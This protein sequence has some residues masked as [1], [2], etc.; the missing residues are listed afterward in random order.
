MSGPNGWKKIA[1]NPA[2][3]Q[4]RRVLTGLAP[5]A[6]WWEIEGVRPKRLDYTL[7]CRTCSFVRKSG[8]NRSKCERRFVGALDQS[9]QSGGP[10]QFVCPIQRHAAC[11][12]VQQNGQVRGFF[13]MCYNEQAIP[14]A[15]L[16]LAAATVGAVVREVERSDEL[17]TLSDTIQ[18]RC[19][20]L[21]TI[22][23]IHRLISSTLNLEELLPRVARLCCQVLRAQACTI[24]LLDR[25]KQSLTPRAMVELKKGARGAPVRSLRWVSG[26]R[27]E[28]D[29]P[30]R[31]IGPSV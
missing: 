8:R 10:V 14:L 3:K 17:K 18:P 22:H 9:R 31:P 7:A 27:A 16:D 23:T 6:I 19:V 13:A 1:E 2:V 21:S 12:P 11:L 28:W 4:V 25:E 29:R 24:W 20:A 15:H 26:L 30:A 5:K